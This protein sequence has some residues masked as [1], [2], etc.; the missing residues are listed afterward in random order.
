MKGYIPTDWEVFLILQE[1]FQPN[2]K[3]SPEEAVDRI[4]AIFPDGYSDLRSINDVCLELAE[5]IP[6]HHPSQLK[7]VRLLW[8]IGRNETRIK[9]HSSQVS[10]GLL[11]RIFKI[12]NKN[13]RI[14]QWHT[15]RSIST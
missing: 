6:Y 15:M 4:I 11:V 9:N 5:Q 8:L 13:Y 7:L 2:S 3:I 14:N 1:F 10:F 12:S